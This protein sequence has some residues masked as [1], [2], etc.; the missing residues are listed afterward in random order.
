M[1]LANLTMNDGGTYTCMATSARSSRSDHIVLN[2]SEK[3]E[4]IQ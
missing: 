2:V 1:T 3:V 4:G